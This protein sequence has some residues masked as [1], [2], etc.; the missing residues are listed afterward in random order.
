[1]LAD[2]LMNITKAIGNYSILDLFLGKIPGSMGEVSALLILVGG[3]YLFAR[4]SADFR[5]CVA[6]IVSFAIISVV[7]ALF[8]R[9]SFA[10]KNDILEYQINQKW[11]IKDINQEILNVKADVLK[12]KEVADRRFKILVWMLVVL[13]VI[14]ITGAIL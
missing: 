8:L 7:V 5:P 6:M 1:M 14:S 3:A 11:V 4:R 9:S 2:S 10:K 12:N 13:M